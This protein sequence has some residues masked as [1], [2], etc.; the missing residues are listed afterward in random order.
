MVLPVN[1]IDMKYEDARDLEHYIFK[2][3]LDLLPD[4]NL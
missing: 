3:A 1:C 2:I 4:Q